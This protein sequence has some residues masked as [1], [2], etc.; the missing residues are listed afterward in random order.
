MAP[1]DYP[2][3]TQNSKAGPGKGPF[4]SVK[5]RRLLSVSPGWNGMMRLI[6][7]VGNFFWAIALPRHA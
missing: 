4:L 5:G 6:G 3:C 2:V 7:F 1:K